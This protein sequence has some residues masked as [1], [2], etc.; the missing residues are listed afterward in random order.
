MNLSD[1]FKHSDNGSKYFIA[2]LDG[3]D[4]NII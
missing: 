3:D 4:D 1:I 2:Y